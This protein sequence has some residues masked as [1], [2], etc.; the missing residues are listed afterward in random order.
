MDTAVQVQ[1]CLY[2]QTLSIE[3]KA[4]GTIVDI[5]EESWL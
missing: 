2:K 5:I 3:D 1:T 4:P